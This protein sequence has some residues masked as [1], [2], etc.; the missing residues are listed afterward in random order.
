MPISQALFRS[1]S[2]Q[3]EVR[4]IE[5]EK[6]MLKYYVKLQALKANKK[7]KGQSMVEYGLILFLIAVACMGALELVGGSIT[8]MLTRLAAAIAGVG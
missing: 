4:P 1:D 8:D 2:L 6:S 7:Q 3:K 5:E